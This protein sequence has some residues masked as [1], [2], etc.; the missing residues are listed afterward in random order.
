MSFENS[1][2]QSTDYSTFSE[3]YTQKNPYV[4]VNYLQTY[5]M[6]IA[7]EFGKYYS[8][9]LRGPMP[10]NTRNSNV[11]GVSDLAPAL[12]SNYI[13]GNGYNLLGGGQEAMQDYPSYPYSSVTT[14]YQ[15]DYYYT[16]QNKDLGDVYNDA[17][18]LQF[19]ERFNAGTYRTKP[20]TTAT[21]NPSIGYRDPECM[22]QNIECGE[23]DLAVKYPVEIKYGV[24]QC[25]C[26]SRG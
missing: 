19:P 11:R 24:R 6:W 15:N 26:F 10:A 4:P 2:G 7:P 1:P 17:K 23:K 3:V 5:P 9:P 8:D 12:T 16:N 22:R 14:A 25:G 21:I 18:A 13:I 20:P